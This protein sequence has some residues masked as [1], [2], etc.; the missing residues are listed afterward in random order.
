MQGLFEKSHTANSKLPTGNCKLKESDN[1]YHKNF[2]ALTVCPE[3]ANGRI[4]DLQS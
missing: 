1:I 2:S 3:N 4:L